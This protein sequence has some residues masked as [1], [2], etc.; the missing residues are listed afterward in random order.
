MLAEY[1]RVHIKMCDLPTIDCKRLTKLE[2]VIF[3]G[4]SD[5][6]IL[7][8]GAHRETVHQG[9][10]SENETLAVKSSRTM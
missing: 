9:M 2:H 1:G 7:V 5:Q 4:T 10:S 6:I 8:F 3:V